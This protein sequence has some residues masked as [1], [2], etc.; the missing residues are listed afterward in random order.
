MKSDA[1]TQT[2]YHSHFTVPLRK[3]R[4][5]LHLGGLLTANMG[6]TTIVID[7]QD[8][9]RAACPPYSGVNLTN[10]PIMGTFIPLALSSAMGQKNRTAVIKDETQAN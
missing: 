5:E 7:F 6:S 8:L 9:Q 4:Q 3:S 2:N 1:L 10:Y